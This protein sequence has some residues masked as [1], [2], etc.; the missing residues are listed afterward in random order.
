MMTHRR[1]RAPLPCQSKPR[2]GVSHRGAGLARQLGIAE[3]TLAT[4]F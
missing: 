4:P 2:D 1:I 3:F